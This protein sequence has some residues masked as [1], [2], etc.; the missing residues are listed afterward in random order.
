[1]FR[2][3]RL[4]L[5][6]LQLLGVVRLVLGWLFL[7]LRILLSML[8]LMLLRMLLRMW[9]LILLWTLLMVLLLVLLLALLMIRLRLSVTPFTYFCFIGT[10]NCPLRL[11]R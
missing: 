3:I 1:M 8:L 11:S 10:R 5:M 7:L 6:R 2:L 4:F 9:L